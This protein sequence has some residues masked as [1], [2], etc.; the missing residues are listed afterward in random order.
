MFGAG[1]VLRRLLRT[2]RG[3]GTPGA[4][5]VA[6]L[7]PTN[8]LCA[9]SFS[10]TAYRRWYRLGASTTTPV[11]ATG[12]VSLET[13]AFCVWGANTAVG[14]TLVSAGL[15]AAARRRALPFLYLKPVQTGF[16]DD[17]DAD[18][19][20]TRAR[21][22]VVPTMGPHAAVAAGFF[23]SGGGNDPD[24]GNKNKKAY[25][26]DHP[27]LESTGGESGPPFWA[28]TT[29]AWRKPTGPQMAVREEGRGVSD[30]SLLASV[31][32]HLSQFSD[33]VGDGKSD[34]SGIALVETAGGV[35]S[36]GPS[37]SLQCDLLRP[38]RLPAVLVGDGELG[39]ISTTIAA[40]DVLAMR[41]YDVVCVVL[42]DGG[43]GNVDA[44]RAYCDSVASSSGNANAN[45]NANFVPVF[46][47]PAIPECPL[48][49]QSFGVNQTTQGGEIFTW[50]DHGQH[51]FDLALSQ[52]TQ[53]HG[54]RVSRLKTAPARAMKNLWWP[55]TQHDLVD[56]QDVNVIDSRSGED[57]GVYVKD[58]DGGGP[59]GIHLRFDGAASWWTQGVSKESQNRLNRAAS[60]AAGRWGHVMFPENAHDASL[61]AA[62]GL[63]TGPGKGW[64]TRVFYSDN[65]STAMEVAVKMAM[66]AWYVRQGL[67]APG[68]ARTVPS[69]KEKDLPQVRVLALDGS[70]HG[71]TL[72]TMDM[73]APSVFTGP[74]QTPWYKP[75]GLFLVPPTLQLRK[76]RWVVEQPAGGLCL[77]KCPDCV[78]G[79][80]RG[81]FGSATG[82]TVKELGHEEAVTGWHTRAEA[83]DLKKR[84]DT[85]LARGY[86]FAIDRV[87]DAADA[88]SKKDPKRNPPLAALVTE[89]VL[90]GA[91][92]MDLIDPLFQQTLMRVCKQRGLPVVL[93]EVFA[94]MWRL[95][96]EGAW[97]LLQETPD[98]SCYAKLLTG[99]LVP[100]AA[101]V[102]TEEIFDAFRGNTKQQGKY[103]PIT[104]FRRLIAHTR[105]TFTFI[106]SGLLHG[107]SYTAYPVGCAVAAE[108]MRL[109]KDPVS[110]PNIREVV[111]ESSAVDASRVN[112]ATS[113]SQA[114][115]TNPTSCTAPATLELQ[116][117]WCEDTARAMSLLPNVKGVTVI[118]CVL[119]V[120]IDDG[121]GG[122]GYN[123][124]VTK[125]I[126][127]RL[128]HTAS[129]NAR[130]LGNVLY[131][132]CA[133]TTDVTRCAS[134]M[135]SVTRYVLYFPNP[136]TVFPYKTD[137][138]LFQNKRTE[139]RR[140][141]GRRRRP[142]VRE[143]MSI[144][145]ANCFSSLYL[146]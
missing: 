24:H 34:V 54:A 88:A 38:L 41:G 119:A 126:V 48:L 5:D 76:G 113:A 23:G 85:E 3:F 55:F 89:C 43:H 143:G 91:G 135:E 122:G 120:E 65:G 128:R 101:T 16:P 42:A 100:L 105:L 83:F 77:E 106:F 99:G 47:L 49:T 64:A 40:L 39:G 44:I 97:E 109:Y 75:R 37:G 52:M 90:H 107:H 132:M 103:F 30:E 124:S 9:F 146:R 70:Y 129:V 80:T 2:R 45:A 131:L 78:C 82:N 118:G 57:F 1:V 93:D 121:A 68:D 12:N 111:T 14:K 98:I 123:S 61:D 138:F 11:L 117:L 81:T 96:R 145:R 136:D 94:G 35:C 66:R 67:V 130:P 32:R 26:T 115:S 33:A 20:A 108:A 141:G 74:M 95:G 127:K 92:G 7:A 4:F 110:N 62:S 18:F 133:P 10:G 51:V 27:L 114:S 112:Q 25:G 72:G 36:P 104:T 142:V 28:H 21:A 63:L 6:I 13:P 59:G 31:T 15:A 87:L 102:T 53:W 86:K 125:E 46:A 29:F 73:Q 60:V 71:D 116:D 144:F 79:E 84:Q 58:A 19:V 17:S 8:R 69:K 56:E 22:G 134:L 50:L 140:G 137:T 139:P